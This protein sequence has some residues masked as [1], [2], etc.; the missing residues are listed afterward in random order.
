LQSSESSNHDNTNRQSIPETS[1]SDT[2]VNSR[3]GATGGFTCFSFRVEFGDHDV[4]G[5]GDDCAEDT[6]DITSDEGDLE[7]LAERTNEGGARCPYIDGWGVGTSVWTIF[8]YS[9]FCLGS[10]E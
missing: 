9:C 10:L 5:M 4:G 3:H 2:V 1:K 8:P 7:L 6:S